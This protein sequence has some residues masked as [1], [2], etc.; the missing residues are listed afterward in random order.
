MSQ[1]E[2]IETSSLLD[3]L[4][5]YT[6]RLTELFITKDRGKEYEHCKCTIQELQAEIQRRK[7]STSKKNARNAQDS[8]NESI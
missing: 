8:T 2:N 7:K 6:R 1:F 5:E 3:M 4:A